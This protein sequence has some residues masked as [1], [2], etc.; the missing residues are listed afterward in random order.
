M[1]AAKLEFGPRAPLWNNRVA[2][3]FLKRLLQAIT[4]TRMTIDA[5]NHQHSRS[6]FALMS[7]LHV[8]STLTLTNN[9]TLQAF[10]SSPPTLP[11]A[12]ASCFAS[13][14]SN[15]L[16]EAL[17]PPLPQAA[18]P[19]HQDRSSAAVGSRSPQRLGLHHF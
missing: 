15:A 8:I 16:R 11:P 18:P 2:D 10:R 19:M 6:L 14:S 1:P 13:R 12:G 4:W 17:K 5:Y 9:K 7:V 3:E